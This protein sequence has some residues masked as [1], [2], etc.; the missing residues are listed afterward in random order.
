MID[1]KY[2]LD[3]EVVT[4][5]NYQ[6]LGNVNLKA[7]VYTEKNPRCPTPDEDADFTITGM[8]TDLTIENIKTKLSE[9]SM[10]GDNTPFICILATASSDSKFS[11]EWTSD[12]NSIKTLAIDTVT[13]LSAASGEKHLYQIDVSQ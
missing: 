7:N 1:L 6:T 4:I 12:K 13:P 3:K 9:N 8:Q 11:I 10:E 5:Y 2:H